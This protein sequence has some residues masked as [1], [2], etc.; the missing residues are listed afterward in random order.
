M[1]MTTHAGAGLA[2]VSLAPRRWMA[3]TSCASAGTRPGDMSAAGHEAAAVATTQWTSTTVATAQDLDE[4]RRATELAAK[5]R[6][7]AKALRDA[8]A[9][10]C[11]GT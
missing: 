4:Q 10:A 5:H 2:V 6:S 7:A 11:V 8:E 9:A 3:L 1:S